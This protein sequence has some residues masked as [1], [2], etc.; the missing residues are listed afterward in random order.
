MS[1]LCLAFVGDGSVGKSS[2]IRALTCNDFNKVYRQTIGF[3]CFEKSIVLQRQMSV[4]LRIVDCGGQSLASCN[5]ANYLSGASAVMVLYDVTNQE[6]FLNTED[7]V[8]V[9]RK[10]TENKAVR[11]YLVGTKVDLY[12]LRQVT[13]EQHAAQIMQ[14]GLQGGFFASAKTGDNVLRE[15]VRVSA[16]SLGLSLT[17][18]DL[19]CFEK[20]VSVHVHQSSSSDEEGRTAF[21]AEIEAQDCALEEE[22]RRREANAGCMCT[23]S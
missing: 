19:A 17:D 14:C 13:I 22:K 20:V 3:N 10:H 1:F 4:S 2:F 21:A 5:L 7:W 6:S 11:I 9:T 15:I 16:E 23:L 12:D 18:A 8:Q